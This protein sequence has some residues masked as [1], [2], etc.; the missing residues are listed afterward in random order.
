M[1]K[2]VPINREEFALWCTFCVAGYGK[3]FDKA[4]KKESR[5]AVIPDPT[6]GDGGS[7]MFTCFN[8]PCSSVITREQC[9]YY[10]DRQPFHV[11]KE[12]IIV[13]P[14]ADEA[15]PVTRG[16]AHSVA[17]TSTPTFHSDCRMPQQYSPPPIRCPIIRGLESQSSLS[18]LR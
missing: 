5:P 6:P 11:R 8:P 14:T 2:V 18:Q 16:V 7:S 12:A 1:G 13:L 9:L 4:F 15:R 3:T 17:C 10:T